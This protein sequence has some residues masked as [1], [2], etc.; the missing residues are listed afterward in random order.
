[1][2]DAPRR[3][4]ILAALAIGVSGGAVAQR[5]HH[6]EFGGSGTIA[7]YDRLLGLATRPGAGVHAGYFLTDAVSLEVDGGLTQPATRIPLVFT[8]VRWV[9]ASLALSVAV[10]S[11][12]VP[13]LLGG[14]T[15]IV[16]GSDPPYDFGD[17]AIHGAV[18][19]RLFVIPGVAL[20]LEGRAIFAPRTDPR[21]GGRWAGH[22]IGSFGITMFPGRGRRVGLRRLP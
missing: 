11:R 8:T 18:G 13:Y 20:R 2:S 6:F 1:V 3:G 12:N 9:G 7:R 22:V 4:L 10:G 17:H 14:Y 19:D 16:Y 5:A 15:R 21:F